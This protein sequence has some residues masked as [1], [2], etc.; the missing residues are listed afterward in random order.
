ME[1]TFC[2]S[3]FS[4]NAEANFFNDL[5]YA[6]GIPEEEYENYDTVELDLITMDIEKDEDE[7]CVRLS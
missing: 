4:S 6:I 5:L 3:D 1:H 2:R 7:G